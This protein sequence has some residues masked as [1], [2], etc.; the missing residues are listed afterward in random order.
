MTYDA[1][2]SLRAQAGRGR[3]SGS[4]LHAAGA[5]RAEHRSR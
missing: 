1:Q 2:L 3:P 4:A 5:A